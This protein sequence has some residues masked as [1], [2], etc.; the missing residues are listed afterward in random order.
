MI[1]KSSCVF[2]KNVVLLSSIF[3]KI[4]NGCYEDM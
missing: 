4:G 2:D 3:D 1:K